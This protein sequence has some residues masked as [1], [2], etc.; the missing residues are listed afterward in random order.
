M[1]I[2]MLK[3]WVVLGKSVR[4]KELHKNCWATV[5]EALSKGAVPS[6]QELDRQAP[7]TWPR[8][9][10]P[11]AASE[12]E[13]RQPPAMKR[14]REKSA[15]PG[16]S[17]AHAAPLASSRSAAVPVGAASEAVADSQD[18]LG[19]RAAHV[20]AEVHERMLSLLVAGGVAKTTPAA[21][22][23]AKLTSGSEYGVPQEL[24]EALRYSYIHPNL[25][26]PVGYRWRA[27]PGGFK[28]VPS[29]G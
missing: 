15:P 21:R 22:S 4:T 3:Y 13:G 14:R 9:P 8:A 24:A 17:A 20:P 26:P 10:S 1:T 2:R 23:R 25:A 5:L 18:P 27:Q 19:G 11:Q 6:M 28:L 12:E 7:T 16:G 29:G